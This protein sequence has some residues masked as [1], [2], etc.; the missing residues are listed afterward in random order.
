VEQLSASCGPVWCHHIT[1]Y[2]H[3]NGIHPCQYDPLMRAVVREVGDE[4]Y[5]SRTIVSSQ[6]CTRWVGATCARPYP[7]VMSDRTITMAS[8]RR[9]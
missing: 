4:Y 6:V 3:Q 8:I 5:G 7:V 9:M 1:T 2:E